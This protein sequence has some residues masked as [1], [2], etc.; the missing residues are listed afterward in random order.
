MS[1]FYCNL[2][3]VNLNLID[4]LDLKQQGKCFRASSLIV[5]SLLHH[6]FTNTKH[7]YSREVDPI[8]AVC[9]TGITDFFVNLFGIEWLLWWKKGRC[10]NFT[11][12]SKMPIQSICRILNIDYRKYI[13]EEDVVD[14]AKFF[15]D[16]ERTY[17]TKWKSIVKDEITKYC[18][19]HNLK[20]PIRYTAVQ[21]SGT[22]SLLVGASPG[23]HFHKATR[24]IRRITFR[25]NDPVALAC[26]DY[27]YSAIPSQS[28]KDETGKLLDDPYDDRVNEWL[29]EIPCEVPWA[30]LADEY[31]IDI[32]QF[33]FKAQFD[34][35]KQVQ[36]YWT[37]HNTSVTLEYRESEIDE[38]TNILYNDIHNSNGFVSAAMGA[39][40]DDYQ[41]YPRLPFEPITKEQYQTLYQQVLERRIT[42]DFKSLV[43]KYYFEQN[44]PAEEIYSTACDGQLCELK[45]I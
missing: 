14:Q 43:D 1:H 30:E 24:Y 21:P 11:H 18:N 16:I 31:A 25:R 13:D 12:Y 20:V 28:C 17:F 40:F 38:V 3:E 4:P 15:I 26:I 19:Q 33:S 35:Y 41:A 34:F 37:T 39:R 44:K 27:G 32:S 42:D 7:Q 9:I 22:K 10:R 5:S 23:V 6:K 36:N 2:S 45:G 29:I 8:V